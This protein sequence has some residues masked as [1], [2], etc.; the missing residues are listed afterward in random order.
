MSQMSAGSASRRERSGTGSPALFAWC[1]VSGRWIRPHLVPRSLGGC[2]HP[3]CAVPLCRV[4]HRLYDRGQ[5]D[6]LSYLEPASAQSFSTGS[7]TS[8][9]SAGRGAVRGFMLSGSAL[10]WE[11]L[12]ALECGHRPALAEF[13]PSPIS[14]PN[15]S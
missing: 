5:L 12:S 2:D 15:M 7:G 14:V 10:I 6:L 4:H 8:G 1:V 11:H 13:G 3:D 9:C